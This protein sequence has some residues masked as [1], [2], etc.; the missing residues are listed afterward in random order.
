MADDSSKVSNV[1]LP[2]TVTFRGKKRKQTK[3]HLTWRAERSVG[4]LNAARTKKI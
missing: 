4:L 2:C 3:L 1:A